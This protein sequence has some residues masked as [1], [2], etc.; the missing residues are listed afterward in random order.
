M[1]GSEEDY[2][3]FRR[4]SVPGPQKGRKIRDTRQVRRGKFLAH[5]QSTGL[6]MAG[7]ED[8][9]ALEVKGGKMIVASAKPCRAGW[10]GA[11]RACREAGDDD[12]PDWD[13]AVD[14][15]G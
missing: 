15:L 13:V 3:A 12:L 2:A 7:L 8:E 10:A 14:D 11:A 6:C 1:S 9:I 5:G 4:P